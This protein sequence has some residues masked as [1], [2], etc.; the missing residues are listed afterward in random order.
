MKKLMVLIFAVLIAGYA[1]AQTKTAMK[2][3]DLNKAITDHITKNYAGYKIV[4]ANKVETNKV[5]T[6][7][8]V[9]QKDATKN[10]LVYNNKFAFLKAEANKAV[11][12]KPVN[13]TPVKST[14]TTP[15]KP[16]TQPA[17]TTGSQPKQ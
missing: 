17:G 9:V 2:T 15:V 11:Q 10:T 7:E 8:V 4:Q 3:T 5:I 12:Q 1:G 6:Y 14:G 13:M 16:T